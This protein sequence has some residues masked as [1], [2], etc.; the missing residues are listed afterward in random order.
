MKHAF[1]PAALLVAALVTLSGCRS[2]E[3]TEV[4][5]Q[6]FFGECGAVY[7]QS[8]DVAAAETECGILTT[9]INR[10]QAENPDIE[11]SVNV[12]AW[13]GYPQL[14][15]QIAA[16]DPPDLVTVHQSVISDY[17]QRGLLEPMDDI[18]AKAGI[19]PDAFTDAALRGVV[20]DEALYG[21][22][23]DTIGRLWHIN[24]RLMREAGLMAGDKP[25]LPGSP[26]ELLA[27]AR[28]FREATGKPYLIQAQVN[29]PD[30]LVANL[31]TYLLAQDAIVF[32]DER[33][34]RLDTPQAR[35]IVALYRDL[36]TE[37][38]TT[39]DQD[40]PAATAAFMNG[41]GGIFPTGT[42]MIGP[43]EEEASTPGRPLNDA[44]AVVPFPR[45]WGEEAAFVDGHAWVMPA[46]R[47]TP[48][49]REAIA[50]FLR[51]LAESNHHWSRTGHLPALAQVLETEGFAEL[52]HRTEIAAMAETGGQLPDYAQ[53][54]SAIQALIGE[55]LQAAITG[56]KSIAQALQDAERRTNE[57]L[58][59]LPRD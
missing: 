46:A 20:K 5:V 43:Y 32:S 23:W 57:L 7:G 35:E 58:A 38:L 14:S 39:R 51:F 21:L 2:D 44:Y 16:G 4:V 11:L 54:Q 49:Q 31:Y 48:A 59:Q 34:V 36:N 27:H 33:H 37:G 1:T 28:Q 42:W 18:L 6:R 17:Q 15:S 47:R 56:A 29:A 22:P 12:V 19:S 10:F 55:E 45:L 52:P 9:L 41:E 25:I 3:R 30:Y 13:P 8:T 53:R 40:F 24:T 50:R 26:E